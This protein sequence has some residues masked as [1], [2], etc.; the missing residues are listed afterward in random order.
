MQHQITSPTTSSPSSHRIL[1]SSSSSLCF[2]AHHIH[3]FISKGHRS[4]ALAGHHKILV[5]PKSHG[6]E[7]VENH[8][9]QFCQLLSWH[10]SLTG[11]SWPVDSIHLSLIQTHRLPQSL[12]DSYYAYVRETSTNPCLWYHLSTYKSLNLVLLYPTDPESLCSTPRVS[13]AD[14]SVPYLNHAR[15]HQLLPSAHPPVY[16]YYTSR[17]YHVLVL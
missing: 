15:S 2:V 1:P 4:A 10:V 16:H 17:S 8:S 6:I 11:R 3:I 12:G 13:Y 9:L 7:L 14:H 5:K